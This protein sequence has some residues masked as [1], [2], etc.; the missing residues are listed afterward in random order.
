MTNETPVDA[1]SGYCS[2]GNDGGDR[3]LYAAI[4]FNQGAFTWCLLGGLVF[5]IAPLVS[6]M[7]TVCIGRLQ[8]IQVVPLLEVLDC[9]S[10]FRLLGVLEQR[11]TSALRRA[12]SYSKIAL[13]VF[14]AAIL[15]LVFVLPFASTNEWSIDGT[16]EVC[17]GRLLRA[18]T[19]EWLQRFDPDAHIQHRM[20]PLHW[21]NASSSAVSFVG[22]TIWLLASPHQSTV[23]KALDYKRM[24]TILFCDAGTL[25]SPLTTVLTR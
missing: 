17:K 12:S 24:V 11:L 22:F 1:T 18:Y 16:Q 20:F 23:A 19:G 14:F 6:S 25:S 9:L 5:V 21:W 4:D 13:V 8:R 3:F 15:G 2:G 10:L 7:F